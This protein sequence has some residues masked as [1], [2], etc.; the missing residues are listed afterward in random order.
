MYKKGVNPLISAILLI[1]FTVAL[2]T[3]TATYG[4]DLF[5]TTSESAKSKLEQ[6][7]IEKQLNLIIDNA[8]VSPP[9]TG[10]PG[11]PSLVELNIINNADLTIEEFII[12]R[13]KIDGTRELI[14]DSYTANIEPFQQKSLQYNY[15][16]DGL[17]GYFELIP[18]IDGKVINYKL[19]ITPRPV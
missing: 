19:K 11:D 14:D 15:V 4:K 2:A 16:D 1:G 12:H 17:T 7:N 3:L 5:K 13:Y 18:K 8:T 6:F 10:A 9:R